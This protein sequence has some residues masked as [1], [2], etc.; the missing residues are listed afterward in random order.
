MSTEKEIHPDEPSAFQEKPGEAK[1]KPRKSNPESRGSIKRRQM[2][3]AMTA[4]PAAA[5]VTLAPATAE[6]ARGAE[7]AHSMG[8]KTAPDQASGAY[9]RKALDE[10]EWNTIRIL[11]DW[12]IPADDRSG[13]ATDAGVPEFIDDWLDF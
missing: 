1:G 13:S 9:Q 2:L 4:L 5:L 6:K 7:A 8:G 11:S 10:H 3:K 12:I